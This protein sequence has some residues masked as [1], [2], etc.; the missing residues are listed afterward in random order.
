MPRPRAARR[1]AFN[2]G[3]KKGFAIDWTWDGT[4]EHFTRTQ[5]GKP[6]VTG[7][8]A[9]IAPQN[10][11]VQFV[12]YVGRRVRNVDADHAQTDID[13]VNTYPKRIGRQRLKLVDRAVRDVAVDVDRTAI[14]TD[15]PRLIAAGDAKP[16]VDR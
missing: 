13:R 10:V 5:F 4:A 2:V 8:G 16:D 3:F 9:P 7:T 14:G 6:A 15:M 11:I 1:G 12:D